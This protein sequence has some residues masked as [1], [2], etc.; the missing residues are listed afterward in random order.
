LDVIQ[1]TPATSPVTDQF[2]FRFHIP[3]IV[4]DSQDKKQEIGSVG[5]AH[6]QDIH[7]P[8]PISASGANS[9][10]VHQLQGDATHTDTVKSQTQYLKPFLTPEISAAATISS[11]SSTPNPSITNSHISPPPT[12][13]TSTATT[14]TAQF[15]LPLECR[16]RI[17]AQIQVE[18]RTYAPHLYGPAKKFV[19]DV[20]L[21]D[22]Y[23][24][25]FLEYVDTQNLGL[26]TKTHPN[27]I[28]KQK[29]MFWLG[30]MIWTLVI[31]AQLTLVLLDHGGWKRPWVWVIGVFS[32]YPGSICLATG[33]KGFSPI[34]GLLGK[35]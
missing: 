3:T 7:S 19:T 29:G 28:I 21:L 24:P 8:K 23:Y 13:V 5:T 33:A 25:L 26:L 17:H 22:H 15:Y 20:A 12:I 31:A 9:S 34:L 32:G 1:V 2:N 27:N 18:S 4:T 35:M 16:Q 11:H 30:I 14:A 10:I 6:S